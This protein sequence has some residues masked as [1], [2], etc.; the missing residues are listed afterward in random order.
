MIGLAIGAGLAAQAVMAQPPTSVEARAFAESYFEKLRGG[1]IDSVVAAA[2]QGLIARLGGME[3]AKRDMG[4]AL[5]QQHALGMSPLQIDIHRMTVA[6][7]GDRWVYLV[8]ATQY[9][10]GFPSP[11]AIPRLYAIGPGGSNGKLEMLD[12]ACI[13]IS[14]IEEMLPDFSRS[15]TAR[16]LVAKGLIQAEA[17]TT[18]TAD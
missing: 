14:W 8:E 6:S 9:L 10:P 2:Y 3:N 5:R 1:D 12:L 15:A 16:E 11:V 13:S 18:L 7:S 4:G 17:P